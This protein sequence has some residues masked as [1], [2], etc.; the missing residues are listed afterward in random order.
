MRIEGSHWAEGQTGRVHCMAEP[1][2]TETQPFRGVASKVLTD[3][4]AVGEP[5]GVLLPIVFLF[6]L[7]VRLGSV[8]YCSYI[9]LLFSHDIR[10]VGCFFSAVYFIIC[11]GIFCKILDI[12]G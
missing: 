2:P 11:H 5:C 4:Y 6:S 7:A 9:F 1:K 12:A 10:I 8:Y 3:S